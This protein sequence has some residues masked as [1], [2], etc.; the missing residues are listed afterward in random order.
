[1]PKSIFKYSEI[2]RNLTGDRTQI[3]VDYEGKKHQKAI[4]ELKE[5]EDNWIA[6]YKQF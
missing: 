1:M 5:F 4:K 6:K 2:S 3:R